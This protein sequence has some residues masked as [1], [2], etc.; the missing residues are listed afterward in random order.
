MR[1][2]GRAVTVLSAATLV[3]ATTADRPSRAQDAV[4]QWT[5]AASLTQAVDVTAPRGDGR[6][7]VVATG[8]LWVMAPGHA[9]QPFARRQDGY[10]T[11]IGAEAYIALSPGQAVPGTGCRFPAGAVAALDPL[12]GRVLLVARGGQT[13]V[14]ARLGV[15][16]LINGIAFDEPGRSA[17]ACSSPGSTKGRRPSSRSIAAGAPESSSPATWRWRAAWSSRP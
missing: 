11:S 10:K 9:P 5:P 12:A 4:A 17:T 8:R 2:A 3:A 1:R 13:R 16:G 6:L 14:L 15:T 7:V